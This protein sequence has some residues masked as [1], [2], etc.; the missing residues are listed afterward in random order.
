MADETK[1]TSPFPPWLRDLVYFGGIL[2]AIVIFGQNLR[3]DQ[4]STKETLDRMISDLSQVQSDVSS[5]QRS[6]PNPEVLN[7]RF[8]GIDE[9]IAALDAD[10]KFEAAKATKLREDLARKGWT[11]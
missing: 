1:S 3:S 5:M 9:K 6:L 10:L 8:K 7:L 2:V 11:D 4:R